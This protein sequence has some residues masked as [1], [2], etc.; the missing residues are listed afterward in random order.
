MLTVMIQ[1]TTVE[2]K[3]EYAKRLVN[4]RDSERDIMHDRDLM[5][6]QHHPLRNNGIKLTD[7]C[8][9]STIDAYMV[10]PKS[11]CGRVQ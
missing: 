7:C 11:H 2:E 8:F 4:E 9:K 3:W 6:V 1:D 5:Y 10:P